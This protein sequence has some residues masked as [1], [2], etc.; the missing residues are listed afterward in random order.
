M[1]GTF[2]KIT[3]ILVFVTNAKVAKTVNSFLALKVPNIYVYNGFFDHN[4]NK[5][6]DWSFDFIFV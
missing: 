3:S 5:W 1:H 6:F 4:F 2:A